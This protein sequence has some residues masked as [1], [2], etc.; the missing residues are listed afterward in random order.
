MWKFA[1]FTEILNVRER[2]KKVK[3]VIQLDNFSIPSSPSPKKMIIGKSWEAWA[4]ISKIKCC[5]LEL[6][7]FDF[8]ISITHIYIMNFYQ[9]MGHLVRKW[10]VQVFPSSL[11]QISEKMFRTSGRVSSISYVIIKKISYLQ[12]LKNE[13]FSIL[14]NFNTAESLIICAVC[15]SRK[16]YNS[17]F[18]YNRTLL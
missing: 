17:F 4:I 11:A 3:K 2:K 8:S 9:W 16:H 18:H 5:F 10:S 7:F 12:N 13:K 15:W 14:N 1:L 6:N